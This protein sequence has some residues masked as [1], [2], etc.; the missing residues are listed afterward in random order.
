MM[1]HVGIPMSLFGNKKNQG[2]EGTSS[3]EFVQNTQLWV[4]QVLDF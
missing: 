1:T 2:R 4:L 3:T